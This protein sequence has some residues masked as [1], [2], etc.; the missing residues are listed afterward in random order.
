MSTDKLLCAL[1]EIRSSFTTHLNS[2]GRS[3]KMYLQHT[4]NMVKLYMCIAVN[5]ELYA[6]LQTYWMSNIHDIVF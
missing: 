3:F 6:Y 5:I 2:F 1:K 4:K